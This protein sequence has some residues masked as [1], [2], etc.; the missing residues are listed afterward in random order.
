MDNV[1]SLMYSGRLFQTVWHATV[2]AR[3]PYVESLTGGTTSLLLLEDLR[4]LCQCFDCGIHWRLSVVCSG[5]QMDK[6]A[7]GDEVGS[8]HVTSQC[9]VAIGRLQ[10]TSSPNSNDLLGGNGNSNEFVS[11][12]SID[13][14]FTFVDQRYYLCCSLSIITTRCI[15]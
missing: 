5:A 15:C 12:H 11:R 1:G 8:G 10:V 9:L 13:G 6:V 4:Q 3:H 7:G 2:K 14:K